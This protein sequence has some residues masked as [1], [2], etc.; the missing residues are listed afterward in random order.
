MRIDLGKPVPCEDGVDRRLVDVVIDAGSNSV[1][2]VVVEPEE[3]PEAARLVPMALAEADREG[4]GLSLRCTAE[5]L[6]QLEPV[7]EYAYL[8]PGEPLEEDS[9]WDVG[10]EDMQAIP[11]DASAAFGDYAGD[12]DLDVAV[13][14]DRVPKGE[15]ELRHAS[16]VYSVDG[17]HLGRVDGVLVDADRRV[18]H[19]LLER[20]HLWWRREVAVPAEAVAKFE[21]DLVTLGVSKREV[22]DLAK[23]S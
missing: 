6:K 16:A 12:L 17:H 22:G 1:T 3:H 20:G 4:Q 7:R 14:Y 11:N 5:T 2:H 19:L 8:R 23:S 10:V 21:T 15:I 13:T 18:T 9:K